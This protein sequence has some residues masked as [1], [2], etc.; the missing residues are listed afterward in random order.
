MVPRSDLGRINH[1]C[2]RASY[3]ANDRCTH[4]RRRGTCV[5]ASAMKL[6]FLTCFT[7][8]GRKNCVIQ[9]NFFGVATQIESWPPILRGFLYFILIRQ[10]IFY[11][12]YIYLVNNKAR[13]RDEWHNQ[14]KA[15]GQ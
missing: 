5:R 9:T 8:C 11:N 10:N 4:A 1:G 15:Y 3:N 14:E 2:I 6:V 7:T 13:G 12:P